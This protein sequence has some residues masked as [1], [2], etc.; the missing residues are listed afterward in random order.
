MASIWI[1]CSNRYVCKNITS[2]HLE[3]DDKGR[4]WVVSS[5]Y[6]IN[7]ISAVII[8]CKQ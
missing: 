4:W 2:T 8:A 6:L 7:D 1:R 5:K 3:I